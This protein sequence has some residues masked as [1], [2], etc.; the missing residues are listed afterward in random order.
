MKSLRILALLF[1]AFVASVAS[2][3]TLTVPYQISSEGEI[4]IPC[5]SNS[6]VLRCMIDT[7]AT[8]SVASTKVVTA[9]PNA[10]KATYKTAAG[11]SSAPIARAKI[12]IA[13]KDFQLTVIVT[14]AVNN[15]GTDFVLGGSFLSDFKS[16]TIDYQHNVVVFEE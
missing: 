2:A 5:E 8:A 6:K 14:P 9:P 3:Q 1:S 10:P 15:L 13:D 4:E 11:S 16:V 12:R 7:G